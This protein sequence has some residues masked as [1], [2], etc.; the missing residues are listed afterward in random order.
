VVEVFMIFNENK[1][2][3]DFNPPAPFAKGD[4]QIHSFLQNDTFFARNY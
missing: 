4:L 3:K 2:V 1:V